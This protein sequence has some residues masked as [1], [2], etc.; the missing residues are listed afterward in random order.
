[1]PAHDDLVAASR[2]LE[3]LRKDRDKAWSAYCEAQAQVYA[4]EQV[5][6]TIFRSL[7]REAE[8]GTR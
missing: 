6:H 8:R 1:M 5:A 7:G 3:A 4:A 2:E